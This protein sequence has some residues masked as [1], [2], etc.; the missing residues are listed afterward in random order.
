MFS[1]LDGKLVRTSINDTGCAYRKYVGMGTPCGVDADCAGDDTDTPELPFGSDVPDDCC[2]V[3]CCDP[4]TPRSWMITFSDVENSIFKCNGECGYGNV[5]GGTGVLETYTLRQVPGDPCSWEF[6]GTGP[7]VI[8]G[9][10]SPDCS[11]AGGM[12]ISGL[13]IRLERSGAFFILVA[14]LIGT[15]AV[16]DP[17]WFSNVISASDCCEAQHYTNDNTD[18]GCS[19]VGINGTATASPRC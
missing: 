5:I 13:R 16:T 14:E 15:G 4:T 17:I 18:Y 7:S 8:V 3:P 9:G 12:V 19:A 11:G 10:D 2:A 1:D 6:N